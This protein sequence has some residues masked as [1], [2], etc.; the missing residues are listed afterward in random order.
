[1]PGWEMS[2]ISSK[3]EEKYIESN[4][5]LV[6]LL[7]TNHTKIRTVNGVQ[8]IIGYDMDIILRTEVFSTTICTC[9]YSHTYISGNP[10]QYTF[11]SQTLT[12][13]NMMDTPT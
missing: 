11:P 5:L 4:A 6:E 9:C 1:M 2:L 8:V 13:I 12:Y 10:L 3:P 7:C